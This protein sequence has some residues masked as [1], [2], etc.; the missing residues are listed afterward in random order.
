MS[1]NELLISLIG[2][3]AGWAIVS[4]ALSVSRNRPAATLSGEWFEVLGC[5]PSALMEQL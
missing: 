3:V 1:L 5:K 4:I 2:V